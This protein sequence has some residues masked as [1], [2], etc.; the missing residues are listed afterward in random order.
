[1]SPT[2]FL[3]ALDRTALGARRLFT[4][5]RWLVFAWLGALVL[6][7]AVF[8]LPRD[9][10][11]AAARPP[12]ERLLAL[13]LRGH[14]LSLVA[15]RGGRVLS[16]VP[17]PGGP[18]EVVPLADGRVVV[19]LEQSGA[20]AVVDPRSSAVARLDTGGLPHG[21]ALDGETLYV[22]DRDHDLVRRFR[23][24]RG[25]PANWPELAAVP[26]GGWPH[27]LVIADRRL[28][29][30][31]ARDNAVRIDG[32]AVP[33]PA[34]PETVDASP[35]T[36]RIVTAG[37]MDGVVRLYERDGTVV[38]SY[39]VGWRPVRVRFAPDGQTVAVALSA[40]GAVALIAHDETRTVR[41]SGAPDGLAFS[42][43]GNWL[44]VADITS[45]A[46]SAVQVRSGRVRPLLAGGVAG[47][48]GGALLLWPR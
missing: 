4:A 19:S 36:G 46:L 31:A 11:H 42:A 34:L 27:A 1:M 38:A 37:A 28:I 41:V 10:P 39:E 47:Q 18:H 23:V 2:A 26:G 35:R 29:V 21:L 30:A 15:V 13:D 33:A 16:T 5:H 12:D 43:D 14:T 32:V 48:S 7:A 3:A 8:G 45:G 6:A 22:T 25:D 40:A 24:D 44:Y 20:L 17:L 9:G